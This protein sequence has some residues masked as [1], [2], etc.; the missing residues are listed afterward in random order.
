[1]VQHLR[2]PAIASLA[3]AACGRVGFEGTAASNAGDATS[4]DV[5]TSD[6]AA[7]DCDRAVRGSVC[8]SG[9]IIAGSWAGRDYMITPSGCTDSITPVCDGS[10]DVL[11][12]TW[13]GTGGAFVNIPN[14]ENRLGSSPTSQLG[15]ANTAAAAAHASVTADSAV[16][17]CYDLE[18]AGYTDWYLPA[19]SELVRVVLC[20][21][22]ATID[23]V[24]PLE[25]PGCVASMR[26]SELV[27][28]AQTT[29]WTSTE[30][31]SG[32]TAASRI[33]FSIG[34]TG[35][36]FKNELEHLRCIRYDPST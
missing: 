26:S 15:D 6:G 13:F 27:G 31:D 5:A 10:P 1:M 8:A 33:N 9:A 11:T 34:V 2:L 16:R 18:F 22:D 35:D 21:S 25:D 14:V 24:F 23:S 36:N 30:S 12:K 17:Y 32:G 28:F 20:H 19:G 7:A 29:Y 4:S 3:L